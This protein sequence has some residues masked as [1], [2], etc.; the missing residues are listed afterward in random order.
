MQL[1]WIANEET[2]QTKKNLVQKILCKE[3]DAKKAKKSIGN[4]SLILHLFRRKIANIMKIFSNLKFF[5]YIVTI[6]IGKNIP[7]R[8][9]YLLGFWSTTRN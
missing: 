4:K 7:N 2:L 1:Y 6:K 5:E 8:F 9:F 3:K